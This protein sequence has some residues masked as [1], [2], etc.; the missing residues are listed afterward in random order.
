MKHLLYIRNSTHFHASQ[1]LQSHGA[2]DLIRE[3]YGPLLA[4]TPEAGYS[5]SVQVSGMSCA[6]VHIMST[7]LLTHC[8]F[9]AL[10]IINFPIFSTFSLIVV[11]FGKCFSHV[12]GRRE[13]SRLIETQLLRFR[14]CQILRPSS[15]GYIS[16]TCP[17][18]VDSPFLRILDCSLYASQPSPSVSFFSR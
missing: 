5:V 12:G 10:V 11:G 15:R 17:T 14:L 13:K 7:Q 8:S 18:P 3:I 9:S 1:E 4:D 16:F 2:D 6:K